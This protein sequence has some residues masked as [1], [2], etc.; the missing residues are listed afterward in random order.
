L[1]Q[2]ILFYLL[3]EIIQEKLPYLNYFF[4]KYVFISHKTKVALAIV[5]F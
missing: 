2:S 3:D 1:Y 5:K 4:K